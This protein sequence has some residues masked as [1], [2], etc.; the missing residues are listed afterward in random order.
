MEQFAAELWQG[1]FEWI[2]DDVIGDNYSPVS[3]SLIPTDVAAFVVTRPEVTGLLPMQANGQ[4]Y[5][6]AKFATI[7][8][9]ADFAVCFRRT[10]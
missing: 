3:P 8:D 2:N 10:V 4:F 6:V 7:N 5:W 9:L 1:S